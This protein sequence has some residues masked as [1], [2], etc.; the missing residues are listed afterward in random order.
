MRPVVEP[1]AMLLVSNVDVSNQSSKPARG[2][3]PQP[4][5]FTLGRPDHTLETVQ[6]A[7]GGPGC[8]LSSVRLKAVYQDKIY[9]SSFEGQLETRQSMVSSTTTGC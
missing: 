8:R 3:L 2:E 4:V 7:A 9:N 5:S 1:R 6:S